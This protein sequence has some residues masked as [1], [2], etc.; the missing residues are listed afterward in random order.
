MEHHLMLREALRPNRARRAVIKSG[1]VPAPVGGWDAVSALASMPGEN[2]VELRNWFPEPGYVQVRKGFRY[3]AWD[4]PSTDDEPVET[5]MAWHGP[6]SSKMFAASASII[7]DVTSTAAGTSSLTTLTNA[8]WQWVNFT[9]SAG[10]YLWICN[11]ADDCRHYNGTA[12]ATPVLTGLT[13]NTVINVAA[14]KKRLWV[15]VEDSTKAYYLGT[16]AV[17]GAFTS[18][19]LGSVFSRGGYLMAIGSW[20]RD[21]GAGAD[22]Y[23]AFVSSQGQVAI[24]DGTDPASANTWALVGVYDVGR[25]LGRRCFQKWGGDLTIL[26]TDGLFGLSQLLGVDQSQA[27]KIAISANI[28]PAIVSAAATYGSNFGWQTCV[29]PKGTRLFVN[30]PTSEN[31]T[32]KQYVMN[33]S[34]GAWCEYDSHHANCWLTYNDN[35]YFGGMDGAVYK[36]DTGSTDIDEPIVAVGQTAYSAAGNPG[37]TKAFRMVNP[38]VSSSD[39]STPSVGISA[40]FTET[41]TL[42]SQSASTSSGT[43]LWDSATWDTSVW[44]STT[45]QRQDWMSTPAIGRFGSVK[46][47]ATTGSRQGN[48]FWGVSLWG[49]DLWGSSGAS[50]TTIQINGFVVLYESGGVL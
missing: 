5:L 49:D 19:E 21:G 28:G 31:A 40:D 14:H 46:F 36:A 37:T 29:Y 48:S 47:Q 26:T 10:S 16:E 25:P 34:T 43:A 32:A 50:N 30:I 11:G 42:S 3:Q 4:M 8:R 9:T 44:P 39:G 1:A 33:T 12:W 7:Y 15:A 35:V 41:E 18:F 13:S 27:S 22:D 6:A 20:T 23:I 2:A 45:V 17:A 24:Y 38:L